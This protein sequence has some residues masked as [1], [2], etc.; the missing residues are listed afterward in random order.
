MPDLSDYPVQGKLRIRQDTFARDAEYIRAHAGYLSEPVLR[1]MPGY[2]FLK[3][4][5]ADF[6]ATQ[7]QW[8]ALAPEM[9]KRN[10]LVTLYEAPVLFMEELEEEK[11]L[12]TQAPR[13]RLA[14]VYNGAAIALLVTGVLLLAGSVI[15]LFQCIVT[16][17][18]AIGVVAVGQ[19][20]TRLRPQA[21]HLAGK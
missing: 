1:S 12:K 8:A 20:H 11:E 9:D 16:G 13:N 19:V 5:Y 3:F 18:V 10:I 15:D 2:D 21:R 14:W 17:A 7:A 4:W 6:A